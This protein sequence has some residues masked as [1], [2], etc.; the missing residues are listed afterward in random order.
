M[1]FFDDVLSNTIGPVWRGATGTV[2]PWTKAA[3][4]D[5]AS[6]DLVKA[7]RGTITKQDAVQQQA[8][9]VQSVLDDQPGG[10]ADPSAALQG[11]KNSLNLAGDYGLNIG[12]SILYAGIGIGL[13][14]VVFTFGPTIKGFLKK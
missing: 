1:S 9:I 8:A 7:S 10:S 3:I 6:D 14:Y 5:D 2:D 4:I 13:I 12:K 11:L